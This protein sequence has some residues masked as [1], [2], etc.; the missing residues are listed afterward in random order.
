[1]IAEFSI[2]SESKAIKQDFRVKRIDPFIGMD[3]WNE[4]TTMWDKVSLPEI[5]YPDLPE[6]GIDDQDDGL[7]E[8]IMRRHNF[9]VLKKSVLTHINR[10]PSPYLRSLYEEMYKTTE[11]KQDGN[12][13]PLQDCKN[14]VFYHLD[15]FAVHEV[16]IR[17]FFIHFKT[18]F[19]GG[20]ILFSALIRE[21]G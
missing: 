11:A 21:L 3:I 7:W 16:A 4:F 17:C 5:S 13:R 12:W 9:E 15:N 8:V 18:C 2:E 6:R 20:P 14:E 10:L 1:M 19:A